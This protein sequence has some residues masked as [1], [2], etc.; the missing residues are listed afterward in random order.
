ML[1]NHNALVFIVYAYMSVLYII[2]CLMGSNKAILNR[3]LCLYKIAIYLS[4]CA[5]NNAS[6]SNCMRVV[7]YVF[8]V[9]IV[10]SNEILGFIL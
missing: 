2:L 1:L 7:E 6:F 3:E 5:E 9:E 10:H 4:T 8:R